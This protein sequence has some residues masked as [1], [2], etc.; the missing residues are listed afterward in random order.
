MLEA[1]SLQHGMKSKEW[2]FIHMKI[3]ERS[4]K[5][6]RETNKK[7]SEEVSKQQCSKSKERCVPSWQANH[8][9][10]PYSYHEHYRQWL[11]SSS[12]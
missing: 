5:E 7:N 8:Y 6:E 4:R 3:S 2:A 10:Q 9:L 1:S 12:V 11:S